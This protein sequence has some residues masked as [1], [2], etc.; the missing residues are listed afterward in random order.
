MSA[1]K[2][3]H[4]GDILSVT[5]GIL[6]SPE[7]IGGVYQILDWMVDESLMTHQLPRVSRECEPFLRQT[8]PDL[9]AI[10]VEA[11]AITSEAELTT[12][13]AS[14][15]PQYGT[16]RDVPK[17]PAGDHTAIHPLAEIKMI[18]PDAEIIVVENGGTP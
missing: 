17:L 3:F 2:R 14:L 7:H 15:E 16:H 9:A 8:F 1:S 13:F 10:D 4:I 11:A 6:V 12:W 18:R 5:S